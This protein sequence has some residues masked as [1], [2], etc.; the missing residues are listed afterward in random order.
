MSPHSRRLLLTFRAA[1]IVLA[2][3]AA[4][5]FLPPIGARADTAAA[6]VSSGLLGR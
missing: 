2:A 4:L 1:L 5:L 6:A 3:G